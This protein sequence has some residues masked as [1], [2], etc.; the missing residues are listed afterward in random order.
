M[1]WW[2]FVL[3]VVLVTGVLARE[4]LYPFVARTGAV[5]ALVSMGQFLLEAVVLA[6]LTFGTWRMFGVGR[7]NGSFVDSPR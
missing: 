2:Q 4:V 7:E 3:M 5:A 6:G 1:R